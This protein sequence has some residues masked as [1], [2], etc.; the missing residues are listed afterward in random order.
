VYKIE[1]RTVCTSTQWPRGVCFT[2]VHR[3]ENPEQG[4]GCC[5]GGKR[6]FGPVKGWR[7]KR[8]GETVMVLEE[9]RLKEVK[10]GSRRGTA[11][12][13]QSLIGDGLLSV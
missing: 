8:I 12:A 5:S 11:G 7:K 3:E 1:F 2:P 4:A 6:V 10:K 13:V 9:S